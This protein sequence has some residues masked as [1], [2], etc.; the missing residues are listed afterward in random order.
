MRRAAWSARARWNHRLGTGNLLMSCHYGSMD[1]RTYDDSMRLFAAEVLPALRA[2]FA[3]TDTTPYPA[4]RA[5]FE[6]QE[7]AA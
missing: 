7:A 2:E 3:G 6:S 4:P 5:V 1:Q